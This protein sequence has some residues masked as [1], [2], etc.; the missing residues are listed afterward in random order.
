MIVTDM[1][2]SALVT[3]WDHKVTKSTRKQIIAVLL[4]IKLYIL[5]KQI[6]VPITNLIDRRSATH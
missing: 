5:Y 3:V 6:S 1:T 2:E 4:W